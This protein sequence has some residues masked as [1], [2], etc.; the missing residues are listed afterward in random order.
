M[1]KNRNGPEEYAE[2][3]LQAVS[4]LGGTVVQ[5]MIY[6]EGIGIYL[7]VM[8]TEEVRNTCSTARR[9]RQRNMDDVGALVKKC[10]R[11]TGQ[12]D[13]DLSK[14]GT[15]SASTCATSHEVRVAA[16]GRCPKKAL[17]PRRRIPGGGE[18]GLGW[19]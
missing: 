18:R 2:K 8:T 19:E 10:L 7:I 14:V 9:L 13:V 17:P 5:E 6:Q 1:S 11:C 16:A 15:S 12:D 4:N 3:P